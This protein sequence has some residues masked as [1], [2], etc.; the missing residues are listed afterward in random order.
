MDTINILYRNI[1]LR[2]DNSITILITI[3]QPIIWLVLYSKIAS[4]TMK[5]TGIE[6]YTAF[7][8]PGL[9]LLV[10]FGVSAS[11]GMMNFIMKNNRSFYRVLIAPIKRSSIILGQVLEGVLCSLLEVG[12]MVIFSLF[13]GVKIFI[14]FDSFIAII[15]LIGLAAFCMSSLAYI[16]SLSLPN[17]IIYETI[18]NAIILPLFFM[19]S[20][21]FPVDNITGILKL[22]INLNPF[23]H[24]IN[25]LRIIILTDLVPKYN[26]IFIVILF[27][28][29]NLVLFIISNIKLN[30]QSAI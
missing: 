1:K 18:M 12:V 19:S 24:I 21:L 23:T 2:F 25:L 15:I 13:F 27:I 11:V 10:S 7:I 4:Q 20:A 5:Y 9:M 30:K 8:L 6:N 22:L 28:V 16:I 29:L 3:I 17:E 14:R 26:F